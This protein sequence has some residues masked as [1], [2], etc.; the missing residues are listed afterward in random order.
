MKH[1]TTIALVLGLLSSTAA[2]ADTVQ[3]NSYALGAGTNPGFSF[4]LTAINLNSGNSQTENGL[5]SGGILGNMAFGTGT[6]QSVLTYCVD[7]WQ[8]IYWGSQ[9]SS[10][11]LVAPGTNTG[12]SLSA[13]QLAWFTT[14]KGTD[15]GKLF[16]E[17]AAQVTNTT[18][19][20]AFQLAVWAMVSES[21]VGGYS[22]N[23]VVTN[24]NGTTNPNT[25]TVTAADSYN[26]SLA[27]TD[28][29]NVKAT[30]EANTIA[31][32]NTW[33]A[34]LPGYS[35]YSIK[36]EYDPTYQDLIVAS[37]VP[38]PTGLALGGT[39]LALLLGFSRHRN[40]TSKAMKEHGTISA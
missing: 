35:N 9:Y 10:Y 36:V 26:N 39:G 16:T 11:T 33:L 37:K 4:N 25:F 23:K 1:L 13:T 3:V 24:A 6:L 28:A 31:L 5:E 40:A 19:S 21:S 27:S 30:T 32:A 22:L 18:A 12:T 8:N 17:A 34:G 2:L 29:T 20:A 15:L 38:E 7:I 14:S